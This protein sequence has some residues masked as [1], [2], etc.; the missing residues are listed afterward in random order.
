MSAVLRRVPR[1]FTKVCN[2]P[3]L[4]LCRSAAGVFRTSKRMAESAPQTVAPEEDQGVGFVRPD[5][6]AC[7][8]VQAHWLAELCAMA[9]LWIKKAVI[10]D[11]EMELHVGPRYITPLMSFL[12]Y[13]QH[14]KFVKMMEV[15]AVDLLGQVAADE[16][17][18]EVV[19][20]MS[21]TPYWNIMRVHCRV[22][23]DQHV[24]SVTNLFS[25]ADWYE[26]QCYDMFGIFFRGHPDLRRILTDYGFMG[27]PLRKDFPLT[28]Y[29]EIRYDDTLN[30]IV[31]EP[32]EI[33]Q[34]RRMFDFLNPWALDDLKK[35]R[36]A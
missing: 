17:R 23:E 31:Y 24:D 13:H 14:A 11:M 2:A 35:N 18:F 30:R 3:Q 6:A 15:T 26:R 20:I 32:L 19:Y 8:T 29:T 16:P 10:N 33:T 34:E 27:H 36:E 25:S 7:D 22:H 1:S 9:P 21:S 28:G 12:K 5:V 4:P